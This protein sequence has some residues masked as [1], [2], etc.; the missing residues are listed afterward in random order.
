MTPAGSTP[1]ADPPSRPQPDPLADRLRAAGCV[2]AEEESALLRQAGADADELETMVRRRV[3]G[4]PLEVVLGWAAFDGLR[5][6]VRPGVFVPRRR[7]LLLVELASRAPDPRAVVDVGCG[8][9]ALGTAL[10]ARLPAAEV[11]AV[12][13]DPDAVACARHNLP[14]DRVLLGD[15]F[16]PLPGRLRGRV[17]VVVANM[18]Y[19]PTDEIALMPPEA[20]DHEHRLALDG[21]ADGLDV[22]RRLIAAAPGWLSPD[23]VLL[24]E[25]SRVQAPITA[26]LMT[27][28]GLAAAIHTDEEIGGTAVSG[29]LRQGVA[30]EGVKVVHPPPAD[31][32]L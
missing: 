24:V 4:E 30:R 20:R 23:G 13:L 28:A 7:S 26:A 19:V 9:A 12:D 18:P 16:E 5:I 31:D 10:G 21:G 1:P 25:S 6:V 15:L 27:A 2:F 3:A 17:D 22:Q 11:W 14:A 32:L 29:R 8:S